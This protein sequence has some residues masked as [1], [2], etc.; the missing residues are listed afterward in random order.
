M[1]DV[2]WAILTRSRP[3][4]DMLIIP[5]TPSFYRDEAKDHWGR[6]LIDATKPWGREDEFE[7]KRLR[8]ADDVNLSDWFKAEIMR[9]GK[10]HEEGSRIQTCISTAAGDCTLGL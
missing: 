4:K 2:Q 10:V 9:N 3:D 5:E 7:R 1:D 8:M 6:L